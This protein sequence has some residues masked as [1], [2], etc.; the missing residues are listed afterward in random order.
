MYYEYHNL[1][2]R[3]TFGKKKKIG[4]KEYKICKTE[5]PGPINSAL[6]SESFN[7]MFA[8]QYY[9]MLCSLLMLD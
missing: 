8:G 7:Q 4:A 2:A 1:S 6:D 3:F 5:L 9:L